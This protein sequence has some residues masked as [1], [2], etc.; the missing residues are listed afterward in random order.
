MKLKWSLYYK[1]SGIYCFTNKI[2]NKKYIGASKNIYA[3][4]RHHLCGRSQAPKFVNAIK[5]YGWD[6]FEISILEECDTE[7]LNDREAYWIKFYNTTDDKFGYNII[8]HMDI[9]RNLKLSIKTRQKIKDSLK[10]RW[11]N[12]RISPM[13]G[14]KHSLETRAIMKKNQE[15][16][17]SR[18]NSKPV[19]KIHPITKET[20][21]FERVL[22]AAKTVNANY[23]MIVKAIKNQQ[24]YRGFLWAFAPKDN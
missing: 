12:G 8:E 2:N 15:E 10:K 11:P 24:V 23:A 7:F 6:N 22:L 14:K 21:R 16:N 9:R 17:P 3:R 20:E 19:L 4:Y 1:K 5:K 18:G 13:K